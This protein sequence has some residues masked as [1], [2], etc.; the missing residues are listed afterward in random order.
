MRSGVRQLALD[1]EADA[2]AHVRRDLVTAAL[3]PEDLLQLAVE[4]RVVRARAARDQMLLDLQAEAALELTVQVEL[5][6]PEH[7]DAVNL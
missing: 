5:E 2:L 7:L 1:D 6:A 3:G 4:V